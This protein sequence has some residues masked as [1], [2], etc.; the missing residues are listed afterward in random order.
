MA[1]ADLSALAET[2]DIVLETQYVDDDEVEASVKRSFE[3]LRDAFAA[4]DADGDGK[5]SRKEIARALAGFR[6]NI[7]RNHLEQVFE[8]A[9]SNG[10]GG[11]DYDE[12]SVDG[13]AE[14]RAEMAAKAGRTS[15]PQIWVGDHHIG[16]C[17]DLMALER[18]AGLDALL[19]TNK[20]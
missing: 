4:F 14:L 16:G 10:D 2:Q 13:D 20:A 11:I 12:F 5:I 3:Q 17:D 7:S 9:D 18:T 19:N 1:D 6:L 15:V 8:L